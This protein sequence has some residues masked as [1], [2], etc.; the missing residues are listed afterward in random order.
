M[1]NCLSVYVID[2]SHAAH[3]SMALLVEVARVICTP[4]TN[5]LFIVSGKPLGV[6]MH[7]SGAFY[8]GLKGRFVAQPQTSTST[9]K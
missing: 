8:L 6:Q 1:G 5:V 4:P 3:E 9:H 2:S 7:F